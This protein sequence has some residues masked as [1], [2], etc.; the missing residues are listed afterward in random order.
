[1]RG[2]LELSPLGLTVFAGARQLVDS[3][4]ANPSTSDHAEMGR[5]MLGAPTSGTR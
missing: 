2:G 3:R 5:S 4:G 1:M